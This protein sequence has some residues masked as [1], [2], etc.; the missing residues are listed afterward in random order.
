VSRMIYLR[1]L[2]FVVVPGLFAL[3]GCSDYLPDYYYRPRPALV[4]V[5]STRPDQPPAVSALASVIGIHKPDSKMGIPE[6]VQIRI[7]VENMGTTPGLVRFDP[8]SL[9]LTTSDLFD[10]DRPLLYPATFP[11]VLPPGQPIVFDAFFPFPPGRDAGNVR[12]DGLQLQWMVQMGD[13]HVRQVIDFHREIL[14]YY[15]EPAWEPYWGSPYWGYP[16]YGVYG[17]GVIYRR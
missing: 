12:L 14:Y 11:D 7:R 4:D 16:R 17:G 1:F 13:R 5:P 3:A 6:S 8:A 9:Q 15:Y 2:I 10:F